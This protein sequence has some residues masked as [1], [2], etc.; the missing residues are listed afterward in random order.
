MGFRNESLLVGDTPEEES[1][2]TPRFVRRTG[3]RHAFPAG[4]ARTLPLPVLQHGILVLPALAWL[5]YFTP[6]VDSLRSRIVALACAGYLLSAGVVI[7]ESLAAINPLA[8]GNAPLVGSVLGTAGA[9][10]LVAAGAIGVV[11]LFRSPA[12]TGVEHPASPG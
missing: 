7:I 9:L 11:G 6:W 5:L 10:N 12:A 2:P 8:L 4:P 3:R 1:G